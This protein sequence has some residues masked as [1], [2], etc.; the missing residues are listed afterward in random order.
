MTRAPQGFG[1]AAAGAAPAAEV[2]AVP[3]P[4]H[5]RVVQGLGKG[6]YGEVFLCHDRRSPESEPPV[7]VA[8]KWIRNFTQDEV[9]G[10]R[11][12]REIRIL[13]TLRHENT[14]KLVDLLPGVD[15]DD[16]F[17]VMPYMHIDLYRVI[18]SK[19]KITES[20]VQAFVCQILRGTQYL[21]SAGIVHRDLKP[22]NVL[23]NQ[24]CTLKIAD[25]GLAR[26]IRALDELT[27]YVVTR[28]YRAPE[29]VLEIKYTEAVDLWSIGCIH[30]EL[31]S[32]KP[33]FPGEHHLDMLRR[34]ASVIGFSADR[35]LAW[36]PQ[37]CMEK[38]AKMLVEDLRLQDLPQRAGLRERFPSASED[39]LDL[40]HQFL[41]FDPSR[42]ITAKAAIAHPYIA[43]LHDPAGE[44]LAPS[45]FSWDF[46]DFTFTKEAL[47]ERI[48][49]ECARLHPE[50]LQADANSTR[51]SNGGA[52]NEPT[53]P[54]P[55]R[56]PR[57]QPAPMVV[58]NMR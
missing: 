15:S 22:Q 9:Y 1:G 20:H 3:L 53:A 32:R 58:Q 31:L 35:D 28:W 25:F 5:L 23:V 54:P 29:L 48:F 55:S 19:M 50:L 45:L 13:S 21:H 18:Y 30:V 43:H 40:M 8:V 38:V 51:L 12:L 44:T 4:P 33:L 24:N 27:E 16:V 14:L 36:V 46:D 37:D 42:R 47:R 49:Q 7:Q 26:S 10:K 11:V 56:M 34:M 39:C 52:G 2:P 17:I 6:A 41:T 57:Q